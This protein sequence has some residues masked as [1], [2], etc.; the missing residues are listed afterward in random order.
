MA[1]I[2]KV[3]NTKCCKKRCT[4]KVLNRG[5]VVKCRKVYRTLSEE[6]QRSFILRF[7]TLS[8]YHCQGKVAA[9]QFV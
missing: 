5:D 6:E 1:G 9:L 2:D 4:E 8:V 7:F 3:L